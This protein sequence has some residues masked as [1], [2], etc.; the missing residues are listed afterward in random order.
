MIQKAKLALMKWD[1]FHIGENCYEPESCDVIAALQTIDDP[2]ELAKVIRR[3]YEHSFE[4]WIPFEKCVEISY[5]LLA[6]KF[7]AKCII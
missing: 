5:K 2:T 7:E 6:I 1:P 4:V 3:V